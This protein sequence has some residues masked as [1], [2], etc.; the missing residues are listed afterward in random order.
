MDYLILFL[1][2][3]AVG[4]FL[5]VVVYR[6]RHGDSALRGRSYCDYC[7]VKIAWY[8]NIPLLSFLLLKGRCR[9]CK[10]KIPIEYPL[11]ELVIGME[12]VWIYWLLTVNFRFFGSWEGFYSLA[13][14]LYW[15]ILFSG[16]LAIAYFD[17]KY[18]L[19]PDQIVWPLI[20]VSIIRLFFSHQWLV[21]LVGLLS[22]GFIWLI[23][24]VSK[25]KMGDGD[26]LLALLLGL[27][28]GW[29]R[30]VVAYFL[31]FLTGATVGTILILIKKK[32][33][34]DRIAFGPFLLLGMIIA[35]LWGGIIWQWYQKVLL[36]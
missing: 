14:L 24:L 18:M 12:F 13:L 4:S 27:V 11:T 35:K 30:I 8:D 28:L 23:R 3:L 10:R 29:P 31:A 15:L 9:K 1:L 26:I 34:K 5:N 2:G 6:V 17:Q 22:A 7:K 21:L 19:I 16:S 36:F 20:A 25:G 32:K 33:F